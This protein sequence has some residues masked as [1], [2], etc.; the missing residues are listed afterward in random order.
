MSARAHGVYVSEDLL[1]RVMVFI[2]GVDK[3]AG[4]QL[5]GFLSALMPRSGRQG[6]WCSC[7]VMGGDG[8]R[9]KVGALLAF[10]RNRHLNGSEGSS[11]TRQWLQAPPLV[12]LQTAR[13]IFL[14]RISPMILCLR[15]DTK[16]VVIV[17]VLYI[18]WPIR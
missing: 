16:R 7:A 11:A 13:P 17:V 1:G 6:L 14:L 12:N 2:A 10:V 5:R 8:K 9:E 4:S 18:E 15:R 3:L